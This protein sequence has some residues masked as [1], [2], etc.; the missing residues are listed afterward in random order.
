MHNLS[1]Y[2][3]IYNLSRIGFD[4]QSTLSNWTAFL[5]G[6]GQIVIAVN[7]SEDST[8]DDVCKYIC[9]LKNDHRNQTDYVVTKTD[10]SYE[11]PL[12]DGM[13]KN[14]ALKR[15]TG[16]FC[17]LLDIDE[18][19]PLT[20]RFAWDN[21][22]QLLSQRPYDALLI[23]SVDLFHDD[24]HYKPKLGGKWYLHRNRPGLMRGPVG[25]AKR[26]D[27]TIDITK[28]DSTELITTTGEL[29]SFLP[30][31]DP[32]F[33]DE[34]KLYWMVQGGA[35]Y[36]L[37]LGWLS[38]EQRLK[39]SAFWAPHWRA[40]DGSDKVKELTEGEFDAIE[41]KPHGLPD[42]RLDA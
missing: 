25:F 37:H 6:H 18:V 38:K 21:A 42:W 24:K 28:S 35:P 10:I 12:F 1:I 30:A 11:N 40:R 9:T 31:I 34:I 29:A 13:I 22:M 23:P 41:Y 4:W 27:G 16:E 39:Q 26:E 17:T 20:S 36:I 7:T 3:S 5:Q 19:F 32:R 14:E 2:T 15:C 33:T 8:Y